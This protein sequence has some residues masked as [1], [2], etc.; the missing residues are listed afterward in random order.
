MI[1]DRNRRALSKLQHELRAQSPEP[2]AFL[3]EEIVGRVADA[4][5]RPRHFGSRLRLGVGFA[6]T[7]V[8]LVAMAAFGGIG[9]AQ[10]TVLDTTSAAVDTVKRA[11]TREP[12]Q[13]TSSSPSPSNNFA[14]AVATYPAPILKCAFD[15]NRLHTTFKIKG[16]TSVA[17][18]A[19]SVTVTSSPSSP[20]YPATQP[21][22]IALDGKWAT[23]FF[24]DTAHTT[25][26]T[27][28]ATVTQTV[29]GYDTA[30]CTVS[31]VG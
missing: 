18:G 15:F 11:V 27:Y 10:T 29:S 14:A 16:T 5:R 9:Y 26:T 3:V 6:L 24:P 20:G 7:A 21:A 19:I 23:A 4:E 31:A 22:T 8:L 30:T 17:F 28:T 12:T 13:T 1:F 2:P 25:P